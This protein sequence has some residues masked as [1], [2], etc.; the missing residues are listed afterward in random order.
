MG[1]NWENVQTRQ[2]TILFCP[3]FLP[4]FLLPNNRIGLITMVCGRTIVD[5]KLWNLFFPFMIHNACG[6]ITKLVEVGI[7]DFKRDL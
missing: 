1:E 6:L 7:V 3:S 4:P 2:V 5:L